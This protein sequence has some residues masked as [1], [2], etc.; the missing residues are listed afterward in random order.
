VDVIY[1]PPEQTQ[2]KLKK[3][4]Q[5]FGILHWGRESV[6]KGGAWARSAEGE[7]A[8]AATET[9]SRGDA[10]TGEG[11]RQAVSSRSK[12]WAESATARRR[13]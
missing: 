1:N 5:R 9:D 12:R 10:A 2:S 8:D 13:A 3:K 4:R 11:E 6:Q 7:E